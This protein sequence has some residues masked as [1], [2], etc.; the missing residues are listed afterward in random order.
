MTALAKLFFLISLTLVVSCGKKKLEEIVPY[1]GPLIEVDNVVTLYSDSAVLRVRLKAPKEFEYQSGNRE[2]PKG[3]DIEFFDNRGVKSSTLVA[4]TGYYD[5]GRDI[6]TV[7]GDVKI[8][9]VQEHKKM[10]TEELHWNPHL[11]KIYTDDSVFARIETPEEILT[12]RGLVT[13]QQFTKYKFKD[14]AG[15]FTVHETP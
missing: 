4:N 6:Y 13:N 5:K 11:D 14:P 10:N 9:S 3:V 2:F 7:T 8:N 12:G 15:V 1:N